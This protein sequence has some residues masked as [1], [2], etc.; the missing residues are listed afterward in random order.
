M[1]WPFKHVLSHKKKVYTVFFNS[2]YQCWIFVKKILENVKIF[3]DKFIVVKFQRPG[4]IR[5]SLAFL[6]LV[7][8]NSYDV[9][10]IYET[11]VLVTRAWPKM[12]SICF[13]VDLKAAKLVLTTQCKY[14]KIMT[15]RKS[16]YFK[17]GLCGT[18]VFRCIKHIMMKLRITIN[19]VLTCN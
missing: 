19:F 5:S 11:T 9:V 10:T 2:Y 7:L 16:F 8:V 6:H 13:T 14:I 12:S 3:K 1:F 15:S 17:L 4:V 18:Q